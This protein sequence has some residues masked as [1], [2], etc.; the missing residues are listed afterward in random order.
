MSLYI[1]TGLA[2][3]GIASRRLEEALG[4]RASQGLTCIESWQAAPRVEAR[5]WTALGTGHMWLWCVAVHCYWPSLARY[6][7][8]TSRGSSGYTGFAGFNVSYLDKESGE[9]TIILSRLSL[10]VVDRRLSS[11]VKPPNHFPISPKF[12]TFEFLVR[13]P[14]PIELI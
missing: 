9:I 6:S 11:P 14:E 12:I 2:L 5:S 13:E 8:P 1:N 10:E 7:I 3:L 4:T